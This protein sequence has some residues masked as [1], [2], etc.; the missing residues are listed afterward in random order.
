[1]SKSIGSFLRRIALWV[2]ED[3][4]RELLIALAGLVSAVVRAT[5]TTIQTGWTG[6]KFSFGRVQREL[7][8]GFHL[9]IPFLQVAPRVATRQ[10]TLDLPAQRHPFVGGNGGPAEM[11]VVV[12]D[13]QEEIKTLGVQARYGPGQRDTPD[14]KGLGRGARCGGAR[15]ERQKYNGTL[16]ETHPPIPTLRQSVRYFNVSFKTWREGPA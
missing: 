2:V 14:A 1:M 15:Q 9:M 8:P 10:R 12:G 7:G 3:H 5:G 4:L 16:H 13:V 6:V 11:Q